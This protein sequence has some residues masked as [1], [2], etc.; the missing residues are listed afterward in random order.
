MLL[1]LL[2]LVR[3]L[4]IDVHSGHIVAQ[5]ERA[6]IYRSVCDVKS[7]QVLHVLSSQC[8]I[9]YEASLQTSKSQRDR[10]RSLKAKPFWKSRDLQAWNKSPISSLFLLNVR[11]ADRQSAQDFCT[12]AI[13]QLL[14]AGIAS[15]WILRPRD[16]SHSLTDALKSLFHQATLSCNRL[17]RDDRPRLDIN[18]FLHANSEEHYCEILA[19]VLCSLKVVYF[20]IQLSAI[21]SDYTPQFLS[22]L[23]KVIQRVCDRGARTVV[24]ILV[25]NW[26][27][28]CN[29]GET[30]SGQERR[31]RAQL[32]RVPKRKK[33][34]P[35]NW[36][37]V[38]NDKLQSII[39]QAS[40]Y[41]H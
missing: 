9:D 26:S 22:C 24:R 15:L 16:E 5:T 2:D 39:R 29:L 20:I 35:P 31:S 12:N 19:E 4:N 30:E 27:P 37:F 36:P 8:T 25:I 7:T 18:R 23:R 10:R 6:Q 17:N 14:Q 11:I 41:K 13:Q 40:G 28:R 33:A 34:R 3:G 38:M 1:D 21:D 32:L